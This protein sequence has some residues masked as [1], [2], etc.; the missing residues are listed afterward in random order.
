[1]NT[2]YAS[3]HSVPN[4]TIERMSRKFVDEECIRQYLDKD[5][6][7]VYTKKLPKEKHVPKF[8]TVFVSRAKY[9][10]CRIGD[11]YLAGV[12]KNKVPYYYRITNKFNSSL[13]VFKIQ[14]D[15]TKTI[16]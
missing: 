1:M 13:N 10:S 15:I 8:K 2:Q 5:V 9:Q 14:L 4:E 7:L 6:L 11:L 16:Y 12:T 3:I